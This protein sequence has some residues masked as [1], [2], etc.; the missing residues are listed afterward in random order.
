[1]ESL[2]FWDLVAA[3]VVGGFIFHAINLIGGVIWAFLFGE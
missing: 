2:E 3:I 1:M